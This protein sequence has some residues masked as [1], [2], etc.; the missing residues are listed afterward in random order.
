M[1]KPVCAFSVQPQR[2]GSAERPRP[3]SPA[4][5]T[6]SCTKV[7]RH[8]GTH[9]QGRP[10]P[11]P[12]RR[13]NFLLPL[14][15]LCCPRTD[16]RLDALPAFLVSRT[17][18]SGRQLQVSPEVTFY[19]LWVCLVQMCLSLPSESRASLLGHCRHMLLRAPAQAAAAACALCVCFQDMLPHCQPRIHVDMVLWLQPL[20][21]PQRG[22]LSH[23][24]PAS[25]QDAPVACGQGSGLRPAHRG[26]FSQDASLR[27]Q[28][29]LALAHGRLQEPAAP[30][31]QEPPLT[32]THSL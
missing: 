23:D 25:S 7:S 12:S 30:L 17:D 10:W 6:S 20:S 8:S 13:S 24:P 27:W 11:S 2:T 4:G 28:V 9:W 16:Q 1:F 29:R 15:H 14:G 18:T 3:L 31:L 5:T 32:A 22:S 26:G 19:S 21:P